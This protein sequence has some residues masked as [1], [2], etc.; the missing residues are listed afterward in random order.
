[1]GW[2]RRIRNVRFDP[3]FQQGLLRFPILE[4]T[5]ERHGLRDHDTPRKNERALPS[6]AGREF[7]VLSRTDSNTG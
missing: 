3:L 7:C 4:Q 6:H 1:M 5:L 2:E